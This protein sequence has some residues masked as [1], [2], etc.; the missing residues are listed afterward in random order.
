M[1]ATT[2]LQPEKTS[3]SQRRVAAWLFATL[4]G[5]ALLLNSYF[6]R[7]LYERGL[8]SDEQFVSSLCALAGAVLLAAPLLIRS[9]REIWEGHVHMG[10]LASLA[11]LACFAKGMYQEGG[12]VAFFLMLADLLQHRTALGAQAAVESLIRLTPAEAHLIRGGE[13][14]DVPVSSLR[15]GDTVRIRP[16]ENVPADG[17]IRKGETTLNQAS[18]TGE[19]LPVDRRPGDQVFAGTI[20]LTGAVEVEITRVGEDTTI[21]KVRNLIIEAE[22][23]RLPFMR[24]IDRYVRWYTPAIVMASAIILYFT[25]SVESAITALV[26]ACPCALVL[27]TPTAMVAGLSCAARLG[28]LIKNVAHLESAADI[29]AMVFD[30]TGTLTTGELA[31]VRLA[32]AADVEPAE[33]L[34]LAASA[35]RHSNHPAARALLRVAS[36]ARLRLAEAA[37]AQEIGGQGVR[38]KVDGVEVLVGRRSWIEKCGCQAKGLEEPARTEEEGFSTLYV[39]RDRQIIG[40]IGMVDRTRPE[41]RRATQDLAA[42]GVR[43]LTMVTGDRWGV[44]RRVA[45]EL[46]CGEVLAECLPEQKLELVSALRRRGH[47]VA[48]VGDGVNDAPALAAGHLG[49][50][51]GAAGN[52]IA[53]HSASI[54]LM[55]EDLQRL[56]FLLRLSRLVR[57]VVMENLA[58]G[59]LFV[60]GGLAA[61]AVGWLERPAIAAVLHCVGSLI[62]IFNS[63]RIVRFGEEMQPHGEVRQ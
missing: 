7:L 43:Q 58:F 16:G 36:E 23:T 24:L 44:A 49:I 41:A 51:M 29:T 40:W 38:A 52:D 39:A 3:A 37:E 62:V 50:A 9:L 57:R 12:L 19:S 28:I 20:N 42:L 4:A 32:P 17:V 30:K 53:I 34:R 14:R 5:G 48:V 26:V 47:R 55:S 22:K 25:G 45:A 31:V 27:A 35:D 46:G 10:E 13:E 18:V 63:A 15:P 60:A 54:A 1:S 56:P 59:I 6:S 11:V 8:P 33:L 2:I 61:S 21:G